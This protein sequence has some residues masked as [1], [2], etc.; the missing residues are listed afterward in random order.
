MDTAGR[1]AEKFQESI[2]HFVFE[3]PATGALCVAAGRL[4]SV[5]GVLS[6]KTAFVVGCISSGP[7]SVP[8]CFR[9]RSDADGSNSVC[10]EKVGVLDFLDFTEYWECGH[11]Y[12]V[13]PGIYAYSSHM[14][15]GI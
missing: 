4:Y 11:V 9:C 7:L 12:F 14:F 15:S 6:H 2:T 5:L 3:Q 13:G 1:G 8:G 10:S